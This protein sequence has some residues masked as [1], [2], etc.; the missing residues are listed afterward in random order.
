MKTVSKYI[1]FILLLST[2]IY[3]SSNIRIVNGSAVA[4]SSSR[5]NFIVS[6]QNDGEHGCGG[7][8]I[9]KDW[10]VTAAHCLLDDNNNAIPISNL[11]ISTGAYEL[12]SSGMKIYKIEKSIIHPNYNPTTNNSD[13]A[14]LKLDNSVD[15]D[16]FP[17]LTNTIS[18][19]SGR[20]SWVA[21][22]GV[23]YDGSSNISTDLNE[24]NV[25][26]VDYDICNSFVGYDG[27]LTRNMICAGYMLGGKD[28]CGGDS[29]GPL[30]TYEENN[31]VLVGIVSWGIGCAE[32]THPGVYTDIRNYYSW[33]EYYLNDSI[34]ETPPTTSTTPTKGD[35]TQLYVATFNRAPDATGLDY[36]YN[37]GFSLEDIAMSFFDQQETQDLYPNSSDENLFVKAVYKNLFNREV[38]RAGLTYWNLALSSGTVSKSLF[39]LA[40]INGATGDDNT[41]LV[42][43][44][45]IGEEFA[46]RGFSGIDEART[47]MSGI[48]ATQTSVDNAR[49]YMDE[50]DLELLR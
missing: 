9:T 35:I 13:I 24:L 33:I 37:S 1:L 48:D 38:D 20:Q 30:I 31:E 26:I 43:K 7:T 22:W 11:R 36:W 10:V 14:L 21:G 3:A 6:L 16:T 17:K 41:I 12:Y 29:G 23:L 28:S 34:D 2:A 32:A 18:L 4:D 15:I 42:N 5:W 39:I 50:L 40:V 49:L 45:R 46:N 8:L 47:V 44:K 27:E 19:Y 25:P